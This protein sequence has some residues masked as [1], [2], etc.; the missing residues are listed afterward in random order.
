MVY[1]VVEISKPRVSAHWCLRTN[2]SAMG[3]GQSGVRQYTH[4]LPA[5]PLGP[6]TEE[7]LHRQ[8][9]G[10]SCC[11]TG[12]GQERRRSYKL[13][14][15]VGLVEDRGRRRGGGDCGRPGRRTVA[16]LEG[17]R[18]RT[19]REP[20]AGVTSRRRSGPSS[21]S[22]SLSLHTARLAQPARP[23][24]SPAPTGVGRVMSASR[25]WAGSKTVATT[26]NR[27]G[28]AADQDVLLLEF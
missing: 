15:A 27:V 3:N 23:R 11:G 25:G 13:H 21:D 17:R 9:I 28:W 4:L 12:R 2:A 20:A 26:A 19:L 24:H 6:W 14:T 16:P 10:T 8:G 5:R 22:E 7:R 18:R 1:I